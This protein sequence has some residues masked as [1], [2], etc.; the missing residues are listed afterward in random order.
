[1]PAGCVFSRAAGCVPSQADSCTGHAEH[2][3]RAK[4]LGSM[5]CGGAG[6]DLLT[7]YSEEDKRRRISFFFFFFTVE[8]RDTRAE[9]KM[10]IAAHVTC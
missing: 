3:P 6:P 1:M 8:K 2:H 9:W 4:V 10:E 5:C 7:R